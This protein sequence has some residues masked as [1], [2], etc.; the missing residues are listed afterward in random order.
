MKISAALS[1]LAQN[2]TNAPVLST[3]NLVGY[4]VSK[5]NAADIFTKQEEME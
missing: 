3:T 1:L 2:P 4:C 5:D